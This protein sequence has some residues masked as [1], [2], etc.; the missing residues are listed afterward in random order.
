MTPLSPPTSRASQT[1]TMKDAV[2]SLHQDKLQLKPMG[3]LP[4]QGL[5][6]DDFWIGPMLI[7]GFSSTGP[8]QKV[9]AHFKMCFCFSYFNLHSKLA[10]YNLM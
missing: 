1:Q 2:P 10:Q 5:N 9:V 4:E 8:R 6:G 7:T 3:I